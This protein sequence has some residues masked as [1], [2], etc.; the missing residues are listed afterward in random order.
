[1]THAALF[2][3]AFL[4]VFMLVFQQQNVIHR[5]RWLGS[6]TSVLI[7][8]SQVILW[9][10]VPDASISQ[11]CAVLAGGPLGFNAALSVHPIII[12]RREK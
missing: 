4:T 10:H 2:L 12:G 1:M 6:A 3:S 11:L 8:V 5:R 7:G 9:R